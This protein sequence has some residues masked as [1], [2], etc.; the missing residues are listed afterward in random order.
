MSRFLPPS[1]KL[2]GLST[3]SKDAVLENYLAAVREAITS[4]VASL[5][6]I[7]VPT[8]FTEGDLF[9][10]EKEGKPKAYIK[11]K[12]KTLA[13]EEAPVVEDAARTYPEF[14][15]LDYGADRLGKRDSTQA[16]EAAIRAAIITT[17]KRARVVI[18]T[19]IYKLLRGDILLPSYITIEGDGPGLTILDGRSLPNG[20]DIFL[21]RGT[22]TD[23]LSL[24]ASVPASHGDSTITLSSN[25]TNLQRGDWIRL[26]G[27]DDFYPEVSSGGSPSIG[28]V[29]KI[30]DLDTSGNDV[31]LLDSVVFTDRTGAAQYTNANGAVVQRINYV[32]NVHIKNISVWSA[33]NEGWDGGTDPYSASR[34]LDARFAKGLRLSNVDFASTALF[35]ISMLDVLDVTFTSVNGKLWDTVDDVAQSTGPSSNSSFFGIGLGGCSRNVTI[36]GG[37]LQK[38]GECI[39]GMSGGISG[40]PRMLTIQGVHMSSPR[41]FSGLSTHNT[42][43]KVHVLGC[44]IY[45]PRELMPAESGSQNT[46]IVSI[47]A[48]PNLVMEACLISGGPAKGVRVR[49]TKDLTLSEVV[50]DSCSNCVWPKGAEHLQLIN[51]VARRCGTFLDIDTD[52]F[53]DPSLGMVDI[54]G[55]IIDAFTSNAI[56]IRATSDDISIRSLNVE[57]V[58]FSDN[59]ANRFNTPFLFLCSSGNSIVIDT[60]RATDLRLIDITDA[61]TTTNGL[62]PMRFSAA[63]GGT[64]TITEGVGEGFQ[65]LNVVDANPR[66][67]YSTASARI[68]SRHPT[69]EVWTFYDFGSHYIRA[70]RKLGIFLAHTYVQ[71]TTSVVFSVSINGTSALASGLPIIISPAGGFAWTSH[72]PANL[73][74]SGLAFA[75]IGDTIEILIVQLSSEPFPDTVS[76]SLDVAEMY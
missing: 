5:G 28:Q 62:L 16:I 22:T 8:E 6:T 40:V 31:L 65:H 2:G 11:G 38:F 41:P 43:D 10:D 39:V 50:F 7:P 54:K 26:I 67:I 75:N 9:I 57:H 69:G 33:D 53:G 35:G 51:C 64:I 59:G 58:T 20:V 17:N 15:V 73:G 42:W 74:G 30:L 66:H 12:L 24:D 49:Y 56:D 70:N 13:F 23:V 14:N 19:G 55:G 71:G 32:E 63:G 27:D 4:K 37:S 61:T 29:N 72:N 36:Q 25:S 52:G 68:F 47:D 76:V 46:N 45:G 48:T 21:I 18:P 1:P 44:S 34:C 3:E 60:M